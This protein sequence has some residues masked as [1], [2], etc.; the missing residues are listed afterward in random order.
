MMQ[1]YLGATLKSLWMLVPHLPGSNQVLLC[2]PT[3]AYTL[4]GKWRQ[5]ERIE[6]RLD[7]AL[8]EQF[9]H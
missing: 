3:I 2:S 8:S 1:H 7:M 4:D 9:L 5:I 6:K